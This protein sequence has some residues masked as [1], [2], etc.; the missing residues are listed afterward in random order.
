MQGTPRPLIDYLEVTRSIYPSFSPDG[1]KVAFLNNQSGTFQVHTINLD[2][3]DRQIITSYDEAVDD[4]DYSPVSEDMLFVRSTG[5]NEEHHFF[6]RN[7]QGEVRALPVDKKAK[8]HGGSWSWDGKKI[9]YA[10][11][12]RNGIDFD[13]YVM[14]IE[15]GESK[16]VFEEGGFCINLSFSH[17]GKYIGVLRHNHGEDKDI[18]IVDLETGKNEHIFPKGE[19]ASFGGIRWTLNDGGFYYFTDEGSDFQYICYYDLSTKQSKT[20]LSFPWDV[21]GFSLTRDGTKAAVKINEGG[22][23]RLFIYST[24][25]WSV[26]REFPLT[27]MIPG[28]M[29]DPAGEKMALT[30]T[31]T[32]DPATIWIYDVKSNEAHAL[33]PSVHRIPKETLVDAVL[34]HY[35]S[36]DGTPI[37][38]FAYYPKDAKGRVPVIVD[39]HGGPTGQSVPSF[40]GLYQ[41]FVHRGYAVL[42]PNIRG[43]SGYGKKYILMDDLLKRKDSITDIQY[44][45]SFIQKNPR[46]DPTR[47]ALMGGS[48]GGYMVLAG[49]A[50]QPSLWA[51]GI[52]IVGISSLVTFLKN[53]PAYR[54]KIREVE[55]GSLETDLDFLE[56][57]SPANYIDHIRAPLLV[58]HGKNDPRVPVSEAENITAK[59][60]EQG[61]D[62]ELLIYPDEGHGLAK[63]SNRIDAYTKVVDFLD[64]HFGTN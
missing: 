62:V 20:I 16:R 52:D 4:V 28:M 18:F 22:Y 31:T 10:S 42:C 46:L 8:Q 25:D 40:V 7:T 63:L 21:S 57:I 15:T 44:L 1:K 32:R 5:G 9:A 26:L 55:Y 41:Y 48:Y 33:V 14:D 49:L 24:K 50:F 2:G 56:S 27:G 39:I 11:N 43:S 54:R 47:A 17:N 13:I 45:H 37:P 19:K 23:S 6:I 64:R 34:E 3:T 35:P 60:K 36:F 38:V 29:W 12:V 59:L 51:A 30:Y 58:I 61:K 53:T